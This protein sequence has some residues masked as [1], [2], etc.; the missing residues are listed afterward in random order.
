MQ[1]PNSPGGALSLVWLVIVLGPVY[2]LVKGSLQ[3]QTDYTASGPLSL[4][5]HLTTAN[6]KLVFQQ[7]FPKF[8]LNTA[9]TPAAVVAIVAVLVP[10]LAFA[11]VR[12]RSRTVTVVFRI[13]LLGLA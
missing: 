3:T 2:V 5:R 8:F 10:P 7:G 4:P 13:V 1:S 6:F 12:N 9:I 11:I